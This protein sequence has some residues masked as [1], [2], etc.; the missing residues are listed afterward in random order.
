MGSEKS[1]RVTI[2]KSEVTGSSL[3][4]CPCHMRVH[5]WVL[6]VFFAC[7]SVAQVRAPPHRT[8]DRLYHLASERV[9][10]RPMWH[11][12]NADLLRPPP[13]HTS[14]CAGSQALMLQAG[15]VARFQAAVT[16]VERAG[17]ASMACRTRLKKEKRLRNRINAFR[18]K[19]GGFQKKRFGP[20]GP[21]YAAEQKKADED[22]KFMALMFSF[23]AE[24]AVAEAAEAKVE[25]KAEAKAERAERAPRE[26]AAA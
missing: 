17:E 4:E 1:R 12:V 2:W 19:K 8:L 10:L 16:P 18:F 23:T 15:N 3:N 13:S 26:K 14:R 6:F 9:P 5:G 20:P 22:N 21:D 7:L 24:E 25:A 11:C